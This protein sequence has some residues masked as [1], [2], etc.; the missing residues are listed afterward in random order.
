MSARHPA[1]SL[2][3][4]LAVAFTLAAGPVLAQADR[5]GPPAPGPARPL[6]L[7]PI[8]RYAL[9]NGLPVLLVGMHEVPVV[10]VV[11]VIPA[12]ATVDPAGQEGLSHTT[13]EMLDEGA[14]GKDALALADAVDF[15]GARVQTGSKS[16]FAKRNM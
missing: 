14:G 3:I 8:E 13:A 15:L 10:E 4:L 5:S 16:A 11:L 6:S 1:P 7:P 2:V 12:G 9:S